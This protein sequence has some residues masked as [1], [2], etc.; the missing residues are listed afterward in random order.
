MYID[1]IFAMIVYTL[2]TVAFFLLGSALLHGKGDFNEGGKPFLED[3]S[4]LYTTT[5]GAWAEPFFYFGAFVVLFS[6]AF[7]ALG[8]WT[9]QFT[10]AFGRVGLLDFDDFKS[11]RIWFGILAVVIPTLWALVHLLFKKPVWMI[12]VGGVSTS[13]I[14][15]VVLFAA[16]VFKN[17][18]KNSEIKTGGIYEVAFW[19]SSAMILFVGVWSILSIYI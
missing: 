8:A 13:I 18:R 9:R 6:T 19:L 14:L 2:V 5:L 1:A 11:R 4:N 15:L 10:D 12:V 3:L 7:S 16:I 17:Q